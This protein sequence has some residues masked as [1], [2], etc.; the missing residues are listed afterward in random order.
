MINDILEDAQTRMGKSIDAFKHGLAKIRTGRAHPDL[1][2]HISISY[3]GV[4]TPLSQVANVGVEDARTLLVTPWE[5]NTVS[6]IEKAIM[7][8]NLGLNPS[9][10]GQ[11]IRVPIPALTEERRKDLIRIVRH[12]AEQG[13]VAIRNIRRDAISSIKDFLKEKEI[14]E[15]DARKGEDEV[16][17]H[18]DQYIAKLDNVLKDKE[19][20]LMSV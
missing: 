19:T 2:Q 17:K 20:D 14:S 13:R 5:K 8:S 15:D 4:D 11:V 3:Y 16:Q 12:E 9:S 1:L 18:T 7:T 10:A 6:A